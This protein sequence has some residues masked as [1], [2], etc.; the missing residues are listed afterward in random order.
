[1]GVP[2]FN[3]VSNQVYALSILS[4]TG[5]SNYWAGYFTRQQSQLGNSV[6]TTNIWQDTS[7][8]YLFLDAIPADWILFTNQ[9]N[10]VLTNLG[11]PTLLRLVWI[12]QVGQASPNWQIT[13]AQAQSTGT[14][15][16]ITWLLTRSLNFTFGTYV[17]SINGQSALNYLNDSNGG[18]IG[19]AGQSLFNGINGGYTCSN[20]Q[21]PFSGTSLG[22][23]GGLVNINVPNNSTDADVWNALNI[24]LQYAAAPG[25]FVSELEVIAGNDDPNIA[26]VNAAQLLFMP[27]FTRQTTAFSFGLLFDPLTPLIA[28]RTALQFFGQGLGTPPT[29]TSYLRST[30]G[31]SIQLTPLVANQAIPSAQFVLGAAPVQGS[32][33]DGGISYHF[34]PDGAFQL[35]VI[36]PPSAKK[37]VTAN[38][39]IMFGLSGIEYAN[40]S[41]G[42][43][44][45]VFQGGQKAFV[46][47]V[48]TSSSQA[49]NVSDA[50]TAVAT[51]SHMTVM[52]M[53]I[54]ST[55]PVYFAQ[56]RQAPLFSGKNHRSDNILDFNPMPACS[57]AFNVQQRPP[58]FP[59]GIYAGLTGNQS[60]LASFFENTSLA[61]YRHY[62]LGN[63]YGVGASLQG[64]DGEVLQAP[65]RRERSVD[66]PLGVTPQGLVAELTTDYSAFDGLIL[67]NMP[68][69]NYP[70]VDLS[71]MQGRFTE[72]MQSNQLFFVA[73]NVNELMLGTSV[74][75]MLTI[76]EQPLLLALNVPQAT[77]TAVYA[78]LTGATQ[79]FETEAAFIACI[80]TAAGSYLNSFLFVA[81]ILKVEM[82][83]W[84]F[85][86]SP[87]SWRTNADSPTLMIAKFCNRSLVELVN[88]SSSWAWPEVATPANGNIGQTQT[89]L[90][91]IVNDAGAIDAPVP[92]RLFYNTV[93]SNPNWNGFLFLNAPVDIAELP[94]DLKFLTAGID[95]TQFYAHHIG[96]SQTP[97]TIQSGAPVLEQTAAFGLIN[98]ED[99]LDL[100][101]DESIPFG[102]KTMRLRA[103]FANAALVDFS[104]EVELMLNQL[105]GAALSKQEAAR[106]NNLIIEGSYQKVGGAPSYSFT[107]IDQN[108]F[109]ANYAALTQVEVLSVQLITG[110][111]TSGSNVLTTFILSGNFSFAS[112]PAFDLFS[113]GLDTSNNTTGYLRFSGLSIDMS[114]SMLTPTE[115]TFVLRESATSFDMTASIPRQNS[116]LNNFPLTVSS[117]I[118]SPNTAEEGTSPKGLTPEDMG[119]TSVGAD[120]D[121]TPMRP[122]WYGLVYTLDMGTFGALTGNQ[123]FKIS[124][125]AAWSTS[126]S[127]D[128]LSVYV[129]L[130]L[131]GISAFG[132]SFPLQGVLKLGFRNFVFETYPAE[133]NLTGYLLRMRNFALS[134]LVWSFP[135]GNADLVLFGQ[136]GNPKGS[137]GWYAAYSDGKTESS[138]LTEEARLMARNEL[139]ENTDKVKRRLKTGRRKPPIR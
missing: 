76:D 27:V 11:P 123:S 36:T 18:G 15:A 116:L 72:A 32:N 22:A 128:N 8:F 84:T 37:A 50:L 33:N 81:G 122:I 67:G 19:F 101:A 73:A 89:T 79:P 9:L 21:I 49:P 57:I 65:I 5:L 120:I 77:I 64:S 111:D 127:I 45:A 4:E 108:I 17:L 61:P 85:Q 132:G 114:F 87:R 82:D 55:N 83:G 51:T 107:L 46:A 62:C 96:F 44:M 16:T 105:L 106:G 69:T 35:N 12:S 88:D 52:A 74:R 29:F 23:F 125:L 6:S 115:Q 60:P 75:Y 92:L 134:V 129:G 119:Y 43:Y 121:Q 68:G 117:L 91:K 110:G 39:Q 25:S 130:K 13:T 86:L 80:G 95:L 131:P 109:S 38:T 40:L 42:N 133:N 90:L 99:K 118:V 124:V 126:K 137:L 34:S 63:A 70:K 66:D 7:G 112:F 94:D 102:F 1:M 41:G 3:K 78:T 59:V 103:R 136:P 20:L 100:Y 31:Y 113:Y 53:N 48:T 2:V 14:G 24:G 58:V 10:A 135:P 98:Y 28:T 104:A 71:A 54:T 139:S 26:F 30:L 93:L 97:F 47:D 56:P 138:G